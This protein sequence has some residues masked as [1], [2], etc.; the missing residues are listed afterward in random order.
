MPAT[1]K[2]GIT[3]PA[4]KNDTSS[5]L[6]EKQDRQREKKRERNRAEEATVAETWTGLSAGSDYDLPLSLWA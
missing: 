6:D 1:A 5:S 3:L 4:G 2:L